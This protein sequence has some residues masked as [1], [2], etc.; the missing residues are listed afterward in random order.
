MDE[1]LSDIA[2]SEDSLHR[3]ENPFLTP[4]GII[5]SRYTFQRF[6]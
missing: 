5:V 6:Y 3:T 4:S 1:F 2:N